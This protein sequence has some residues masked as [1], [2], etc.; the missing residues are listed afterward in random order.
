MS[1]ADSLTQSRQKAYGYW[2]IDGIFELS[3]GSFFLFLGIFLIMENLAQGTWMAILA[4]ILLIV[5]VIGGSFVMRWL[6]RKWKE[7]ITFPR[8]GYVSYSRK[9]RSARILG[10]GLIILATLAMMFG[11][12]HFLG[13][14]LVSWALFTGILLGIGLFLIGWRTR[15]KRFLLHAGLSAVLGI[16]LTFC[17]PDNQVG[18]SV[19]YIVM[20]LLLLTSGLVY[21]L[22]YLRHH[23]KTPEAPDGQ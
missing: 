13:F 9:K 20:G 21:L 4:D 16:G 15:L 8:T 2:Y 17:A 6:V 14:P 3:C 5:I 1:T 7:R 10:S 18:L 12:F 19:F 11:L 22:K 23:P